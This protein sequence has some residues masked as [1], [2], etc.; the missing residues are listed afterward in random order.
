LLKWILLPL[1]SINLFALEISMDSAKDDF[2]RYSTLTLSDNKKFLCQEIKDDF[3]VTTEV[4]CAFSKRPFQSVKELQNDFFKVATFIKKDTFFISVK[5]YYKIDLKPKI[6]DLTKED[7]TYLA[8]VTL[9]KKWLILGYKKNMPLIQTNAKSDISINFPFFS[10]KDRFPYVGSLDIKG[11]PVYIKKV[12]DVKDY[13]KVKEYY[14]DKQYELCM[15][16][17]DDILEEYPN[18]LFKAELIYYK[19]KLYAKLK[20]YDN[21]ISFSKEYLR[22]YSA[23]KNI[24]EILSLIAQAYSQIGIYIDADYFFDRLFSEH[25]DS[26]YTQWGY[27]YKAEMLAAGGATSKAIKFYKK[28]LRGT[29]DIDVAVTAAYKLAQINQDKSLKESAKYVEKIV[30][31]KP[32]FFVEDY[33][34]S[35]LMMNSFSDEDDFLS[36]SMIAGSMLDAF[37]PSHDDYETLLKDRALWLAKTEDKQLALA[38][39]NKYLKQFPDGDF[40]NPVQVAKDALFFDTS[41]SN[42]TQRLVEYD[43]LIEEY[44][45]DTIGDRAIYEKAK[46][47]LSELEYALV[48]DSKETLLSL[49]EDKYSDTNE[50][51]R[52]AA[53]GV[54]KNSLES[55]EC[56]EVLVISNDYNITLSNKWD[57]GIYECAMKGGDY[58]LG[59]SITLKNLKSEDLEL[60]KKW[61]YR[62]IKVDF[63]TGNYSDVIE[64]SKD[65]I[66][67]IEDDEHS[68]YKDVYRYLFDTYDRLEKEDLMLLAMSQIEDVFDV[69]YKDIDRYVSVMS[70]GNQR[71]D[72]NIVIKYGSIVMEIQQKSKSYAQSPY[73]EFTLYQSYIDKEDYLKALEIIKVLDSVE[74]TPKQRARQK[75]FLGTSLTKLWRDDEAKE[76]YKA[77]I[78]AAPTTAWAKLAQSAL[79]L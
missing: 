14:N 61:L 20:D 66:L 58:Q 5:P 64:A 25:K 50:I 2:S 6:F 39:L 1:L 67:L 7:T 60:R 34:A 65:L 26:V 10:D 29:K 12:G 45:G 75:Y 78:D 36:A 11:N 57:D 53:I 52:D 33:T 47:L 40:I 35:K 37:G 9:S 79:E 18:T 44:Y 27:I 54:M 55:K 41:D 59:K 68:E 51:I 42:I 15:D 4:I 17:A 63:T 43:K 72:D 32:S 23:D 21:V 28:A 69:D 76:A 48:L 77:A 74:L 30:K 16:I 70:I 31:A 19:I 8:D 13:L 46:L 71:N 49:D 3:E 38:A 22:E 24:P 56:K 62:Y 73:V